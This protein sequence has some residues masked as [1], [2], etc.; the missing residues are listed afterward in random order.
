MPRLQPPEGFVTAKEATKLIGVSDSML[1]RYVKEGKINRHGPRDRKQKFYSRTELEAFIIAR[2]VTETA[3]RKGRWRLNASSTFRKAT[4][5]DLDAIINMSER[6]YPAAGLP[7]RE[8]WAGWIRKNPESFHVLCNQ[9]SV[10]VAYATILVM[11][12]ATISLFIQDK[13][14]VDEIGPDKLELF[15]PGE[16]LHIYIMSLVVDPQYPAREKHEYGARLISS[17]FSFFLDLAQ[18]GIEVETITARSHTADGMRLMRK[19]GFPQ[20]KSPVP[21]KHLFIVKVE[22]SG[23]HILEKYSELLAEWRTKHQQ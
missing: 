14:P 6:A 18:R 12:P 8:T 5:Q 13:L 17:L 23:L 4:L 22:E 10:I 3:Y 19:L 1:S 16:P 9:Q 7:L 2:Q 20:I 15:H 21:G 11:R